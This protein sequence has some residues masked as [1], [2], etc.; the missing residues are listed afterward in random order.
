MQPLYVRPARLYRSLWNSPLSR[1]HRQLGQLNMSASSMSE[2]CARDFIQFLVLTSF[3]SFISFYPFCAVFTLY[4]YILACTNPDDCEQDVQLLESIGATMAEAS[5]HRTDFRPLERTIN[6]LNKVSRTIQDERRRAAA[7]RSN[8]S[9]GETSNMM[10]DFDM[11]T[12]ASFPDFP[13]NFDDANQPL[14]FVRALEN[15]FTGRN[16]HEGW[17]DAGAGLDDPMAG[18]NAT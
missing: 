8:P 11:S 2:T 17:W 6:A 9:A 13:I 4:E 14:C 5:V 1:R 3:F 16:W 12:F 15:D 10:P 18:L 7:G